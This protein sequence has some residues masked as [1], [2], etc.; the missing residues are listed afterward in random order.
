M[1]CW[2][3]RREP[4][5]I[6]RIL[7]RFDPVFRCWNFEQFSYSF[8]T[9]TKCFPL[10]ALSLMLTIFSAL[11]ADDYILGPDSQFK[12]EVPHGR[13]ERFKLTESVVFPGKISPTFAT[14]ERF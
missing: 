12:P 14:G 2:R 10:A 11:A 7:E 4:G 9:M 3:L 8:L 6:P 5:L 1:V 13:V